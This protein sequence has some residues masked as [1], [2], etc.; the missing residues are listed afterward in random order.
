VSEN[1]QR[2]KLEKIYT[3]DGLF[4][5]RIKNYETCRNIELVVKYKSKNLK[6]SP[7]CVKNLH[8]ESCYCPVSYENF[9]S[10]MQCDRENEQIKQDLKQFASINFTQIRRKVRDQYENSKSSSLCNYVIKNNKIYRKCYGEYVGFKMFV[11]GFLNSLRNKVILPDIEFLFNLGDWP[12]VRK[13]SNNLMPIFSWC[14]SRDTFDIV[15]PTYDISESTINM[16]HRVVL[17]IMSVQ[18]ENYVWSEKIERAFFRGRDSRRERLELVTLAKN[19]PHLVNASITNFFFFQDE[20]SKYGPRTE[21]I[22]FFDF[23]RYKYQINIDGTVSSYRFPYLLAGNSVVLK[24]N[25]PYYEHFYHK[26][27]PYQHYIPYERD[28]TIDL[29]ERIQW[30]KDHELEAKMISF[31][32]RQFV[33]DNLMPRNIYC[34]YAL[35]FEKFSKLIVSEIK[36]HADMETVE[37]KSIKCEC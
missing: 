12:L 20:I 3:G 21:H 10:S 5:L 2:F 23:F 27:N 1:C 34:Y 22:S 4:I 32:A 29:V 24:Q 16:M 28:P 37:D 8:P 17:D 13:N 35:L 14:G 30:L 31:N 18:R 9:M 11:D 7:I 33:R 26:I 19:H 36:V 15:L 25:S 6:G